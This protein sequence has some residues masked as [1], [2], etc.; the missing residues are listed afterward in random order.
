MVL[1]LAFAGLV[2]AEAGASHPL[3]EV[4]L[5]TIRLFSMPILSA[6]LLFSALFVM[7]FLMPFYLMLP[8]ALSPREAGFMMM[9]PFVFLFIVSPVSGGLSDRIGSRFLCTLGLAVLMAALFL[10]AGL[11]PGASR[12]AV[13][14]RLALAGIGVALFISPNSAAAMGAVPLRHRGLASGMVATAR[15]LGMVS[16]VALA[17]AVFGGG[18]RAG[19][20]GMSLS[21]YGPELEAVF[22]AVFRTAMMA[23]G[24]VAA[25]GT[26]VSFLRGAERPSGV[27]MRGREGAD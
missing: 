2:R 21:A 8:C 13:A 14:F 24:V 1:S 5:F 10:L 12:G 27:G 7:V 20:G 11:S 25:V 3:M 19:S 6:V 16:G 26:A 18:F 17:G 23:C 15:N 4:S 22:M 9:V